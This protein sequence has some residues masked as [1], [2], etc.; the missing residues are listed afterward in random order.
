MGVSSDFIQVIR[1]QK[2]LF[3]HLVIKAIKR[4]TSLI[5]LMRILSVDNYSPY[6]FFFLARGIYLSTLVKFFV[7][8]YFRMSH[9]CILWDDTIYF[10]GQDDNCLGVVVVVVNDDDDDDDDDYDDD[11]DED[12]D[13][14][15]DDDDDDDDGDDDYNDVDDDDDDDDDD[16]NYK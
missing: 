11:V 3:S 9:N 1:E 10:V 5:V 16:Q 15:D 12:D 4:S 13:D 7:F 6:M 2:I 14:Y 8:V